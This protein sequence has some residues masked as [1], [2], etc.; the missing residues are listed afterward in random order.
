ML[1]AYYFRTFLI[2]R[3]LATVLQCR[4]DNGNAKLW[5]IKGAWERKGGSAVQRQIYCVAPVYCLVCWT[6]QLDL[7]LVWSTLLTADLFT[8]VCVCVWSDCS[9]RCVCWLLT[10]S[11]R[12][13][14]VCACAR[15]LTADC[16]QRCVCVCVLTVHSGV[17][18][19]CWLFT[20][21]CVCVCF[22]S[23]YDCSLGT[24]HLTAS[25]IV[26]EV[27]TEG[28]AGKYAAVLYRS[29]LPDP[30]IRIPHCRLYRWPS[31]AR[32]VGTRCSIQ[33]ISTL[34]Q[35]LS[36]QCLQSDLYWLA[37]LWRQFQ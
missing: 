36:W 30:R 12:C 15:A 35:F 9:Q 31:D 33:Q 7:E 19:D 13:V 28:L 11:Q 17:C 23:Q 1:L 22:G 10:C 14:C 32:Q 6:L 26:N 29:A 21:V 20:V 34:R 24:F 16:S 4:T 37:V 27:H 3:T 8:A 2:I 5:L 25:A 18:A